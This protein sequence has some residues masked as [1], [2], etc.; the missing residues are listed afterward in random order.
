MES[1]DDTDG[2]PSLRCVCDERTTVLLGIVVGL[3]ADANMRVAG[4]ATDLFKVNGRYALP[5]FFF[6]VCD[7]C[8]PYGLT[9]TLHIA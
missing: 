4:E 3:V 7:G 9:L 6:R 5:F 1:C 8:I 2:S